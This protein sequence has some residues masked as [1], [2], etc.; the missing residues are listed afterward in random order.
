[1]HFIVSC[2]GEAQAPSN[3]TAVRGRDGTGQKER[4][5]DDVLR[6]GLPSRAGGRGRGGGGRGLLNVPDE[7]GYVGDYKGE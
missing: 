2:V 4:I 1:M 6:C 7:S 3:A 5:T